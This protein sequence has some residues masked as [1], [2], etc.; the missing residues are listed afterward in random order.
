MGK[1]E[2]AVYSKFPET[3]RAGSNRQNAKSFLASPSDTECGSA[4]FLLISTPQRQ[5]GNHLN[6][7]NKKMVKSVMAHLC[8]R[9]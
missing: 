4:E 5:T 6:I 7:Q 8:G 9:K 2:E 1:G 3:A